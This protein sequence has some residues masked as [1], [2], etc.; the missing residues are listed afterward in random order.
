MLAISDWGFF[1]LNVYLLLKDR[2][3]QSMSMGGAERGEDTESE[4]GSRLWAISTEPDAGLKL[5][6]HEFM[7]WAKIGRLTDWATQ[8]SLNDWVLNCVPTFH[9]DSFQPP[10]GTQINN[11]LK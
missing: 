7:T 4:V 10:G 3:R 2:E 5:T 1:S 11:S 8:V 6:N 9:G